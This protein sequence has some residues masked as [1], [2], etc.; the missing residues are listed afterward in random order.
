[1]QTWLGKLKIYH[2]GGQQNKCYFS[3]KKSE[4][5]YY[6][7]KI[8]FGSIKHYFLSKWSSK[9][10]LTIYKI[11]CGLNEHLSCKQT[12]VNL[13]LFIKIEGKVL[14]KPFTFIRKHNK[15]FLCVFKWPTKYYLPL[16]FILYFNWTLDCWKQYKCSNITHVRV[17]NE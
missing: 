13:F 6:N 5:A 1:M 8:I 2:K 10:K 7:N 15:S 17:I 3:N 14:S 12:I 11:N 9:S 16:F 4:I